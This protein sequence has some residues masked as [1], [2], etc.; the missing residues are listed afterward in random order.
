MEYYF[1]LPKKDEER[2]LEVHKKSIVIDG[3]NGSLKYQDLIFKNTSSYLKKLVDAGITA[4]NDTVSYPDA[5]FGQVLT[6]ICLRYKWVESNPDLAMIVFSADDIERAK[7]DGKAGIICGTQN[8]SFLERDLEKLELSRV[9]GLKIVGLAYQYKNFVGDGCGERTDS[10]LGKFGVKLVEEMDRN[11]VVIDLSHAGKATTIDAIEISKNPTV[12]S[13]SN[14]KALCKHVRNIDDEQIKAVAEKKGV[15]GVAGYSPCLSPQ[16]FVTEKPKLE[17][18]LDQIDYITKLV[19]VDYVGIGSDVADA[20][21]KDR[22][23]AA[24]KQYPEVYTTTWEAMHP[25]GLESPLEMINV[26]MGLVMRGYSDQDIMK[27]LGGN[28]IRV[29][30]WVWKKA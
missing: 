28:W 30:R 5:D 4:W 17:L 27:I 14:A 29:F 13:H 15:V 2:A 25:R 3:E 10:G 20:C 7:R 9:L 19:G 8:S 6:D 16:E 12:F 26:T 23:D 21:P 11:G 22:I 1:K 18:M 24:R